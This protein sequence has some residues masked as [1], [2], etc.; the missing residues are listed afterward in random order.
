M[1]SRDYTRGDNNAPRSKPNESLAIHWFGKPIYSGSYIV[2]YIAV[3]ES[4]WGAFGTSGEL[5][6]VSHSEDAARRAVL[7]GAAR[8]CER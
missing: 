3:C 4:G 1:N 6:S 8:E 2:R 7:A 5:I